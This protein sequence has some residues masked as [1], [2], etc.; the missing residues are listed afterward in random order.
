M[1]RDKADIEV[2]GCKLKGVEM[3]G[4]SELE[5]VAVAREVDERMARLAKEQA[6]VDSRK[7]AIMAALEFAADLQRLQATSK[8]QETVSEGRLDSMIAT[9]ERAMEGVKPSR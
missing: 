4:L 2:A 3:E 9:L 1:N 8:N 7:L 6:I 5:I